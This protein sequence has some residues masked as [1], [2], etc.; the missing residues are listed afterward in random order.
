[1]LITD[2]FTVLSRLAFSL[3]PEWLFEFERRMLKL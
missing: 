3:T 2:Y 1:L